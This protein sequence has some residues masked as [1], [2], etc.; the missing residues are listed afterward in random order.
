MH[1]H[2]HECHRLPAVVAGHPVFLLV[3][4]QQTVVQRLL[5]F[6]VVVRQNFQLQFGHQH[7]RLVAHP[8]CF[9]LLPPRLLLAV[10][11]SVVAHFLAVG[12]GCGHVVA[13]IPHGV[14]G[15]VKAIVAT[16]VVVSVVIAMS[17]T[18]MGSNRVGVGTKMVRIRSGVSGAGGGCAQV[19]VGMT[20]GFDVTRLQIAAAAIMIR[21]HA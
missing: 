6:L 9:I 11:P 16:V 4:C 21:P 12:C 20:I 10:P 5:C 18:S 8:S 1:A 2:I 14:A 13:D 17:A 19:D 7:L 3:Y 15:S